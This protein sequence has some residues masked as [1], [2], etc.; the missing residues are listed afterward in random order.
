MSLTIVDTEHFSDVELA[1]KT[2]AE[3]VQDLTVKLSRIRTEVEANWKGDGAS[4]FD[5]LFSC[6]KLQ[7][8]DIS[9]DFW[10]LYEELCDIEGGYLEGDQA[11][12]TDIASGTLSTTQTSFSGGGRSSGSS[13]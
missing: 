9:D 11:L 7:V 12:A 6:V 4:E 10:D 5:T 3:E 2:I 8:D 13:S 1:A